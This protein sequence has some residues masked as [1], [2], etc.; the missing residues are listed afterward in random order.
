[1]KAEDY[2]KNLPAKVMAVGV[3]FFNKSQEL[4]IVKP[5]YKEHWSIPGGVVDRDESLRDACAR[6]VKEEIDLEVKDLKLLCV[7][8]M[9]A[10]V[11]EYIN[12]SENLQFVFAGGILTT[13]QIENIILEK[14]ELAEYKFMK[15]ELALP[16]LNKNLSNRLP[17]CFDAL[18]DDS[19]FY[20]EGG[21]QRG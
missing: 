1:M 14:K 17:A 18:K 15:P 9:S 3:L 19:V 6:E 4:L 10:R 12:K 21:K 16:L 20:L 11:S 2:Y 13:N 7:D 5:T 8:Y